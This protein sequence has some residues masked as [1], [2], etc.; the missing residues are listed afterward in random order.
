MRCEQPWQALLFA[1]EN[2]EPTSLYL[3]KKE[4][5][6]RMHPSTRTY[7]HSCWVGTTRWGIPALRLGVLTLVAS[8]LLGGCSTHLGY[9][10]HDV[11]A[12]SFWPNVNGANKPQSYQPSYQDVKNWAYNVSDGYDSRATLNRQ[13]LYGGAL[14]AVAGAS[15]LVGLAA[16]APGSSAIIGIPIGTTFL[17]GAMAIYNNEQ[18]AVIYGSASQTIRDVLIRSDCRMAKSKCTTADPSGATA[19][20]PCASEKAVCLHAEV[21]KVMRKVNDHITL[22]DPKNVADRLKAVAS[23]IEAKKAVAAQKQDLAK[24]A[25]TAAK[26]APQDTQLKSAAETAAGEAAKAGEEADKAQAENTVE[27]LSAE[28][29]DFSDLKKLPELKDLCGEPPVCQL[30]E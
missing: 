11:Y 12:P 25:A 14:V 4:A 24:K 3:E 18:K 17:S 27:S 2:H 29:N 9:V 8:L 19:D 22:L 16:F 7:A 26:E 6:T 30:A 28:A 1:G 23:S 10:P 5:T 15:A 21:S 20:P 13:A